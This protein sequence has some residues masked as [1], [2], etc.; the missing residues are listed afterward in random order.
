MDGEPLNVESQDPSAFISIGDDFYSYVRALDPP[1]DFGDGVVATWQ[2]V[3]IWK[4]KISKN[5]AGSG[6]KDSEMNCSD[7]GTS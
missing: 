3:R 4:G 5:E 6:R 7:N 2:S 1:L